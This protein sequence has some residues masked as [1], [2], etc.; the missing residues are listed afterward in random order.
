M[1]LIMENVFSLF[2]I[3]CKQ[4]NSLV[5]VSSYKNISSAAN[6]KFF[7]GKLF[8]LCPV[9]VLSTAGI[10][11]CRDVQRKSL[12]SPHLSSSDMYRGCWRNS[13]S[14]DDCAGKMGFGSTG[15][16]LNNKLNKQV[17]A[18]EIVENIFLIFENIFTSN[19]TGKF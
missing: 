18:F 9:P 14:C 10:T 6:N 8:F 19:F 11:C 2:F 1:D 13:H 12:H 7:V 3:I 16:S 4:K 5:N 17:P 15:Y